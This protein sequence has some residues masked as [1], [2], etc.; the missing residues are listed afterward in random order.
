MPFYSI[1]PL[2]STA[3]AD[4]ELEALLR[5]VYVGGGFTEARLA[6][7]MFRAANV[8]AR[9]EV[10]VARSSIQALLGVVVVV[11]FGSP[12][13]RFARLGEA[14]L[15]L[16]AVHPDARG[17]GIGSALIGAALRAAWVAGA[18]RLLLWTQSSMTGARRLYEKHGFERVPA[19][20]FSRGD[21]RFLVLARRIDPQIHSEGATAMPTTAQ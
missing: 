12:A 4:D 9:G 2:A 1:A 11:P 13:V 10:I 5:L 17:R 16:L 3:I 7:V 8:K 21:R 6:D 19:L 20:D 14:E 18:S 15:H